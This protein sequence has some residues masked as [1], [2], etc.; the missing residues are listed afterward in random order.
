VTTPSAEELA[1]A[2]INFSL[3]EALAYLVA[4]GIYDF[5]KKGY[6]K[7]KKI[8]QD[9]Q[10]E[11]KYAFV[12][13]KEE[14]NLLLNS[15]KNPDYREIVMLIPN[16]RYI[17]LIRTGQLIDYYLKQDTPRISERVRD[18]KLQ[19]AN[20]PNGAKLLKIA[21]LP[22]TPYFSLIIKALHQLKRKGYSP[23]F[24]EEKFEE[25]VQDWTKT[26]KL[27]KSSDSIDGV[28]NFCEKQMQDKTEIFFILGMK[29]ASEKVERV[30]KILQ[31]KGILENNDYTYKLTKSELGVNPRVELM[32]FV[33]T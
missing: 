4:H 29:S 31:E 10:N 27:V 26:A 17:D 19:I 33:K 12:P 3:K 21:T 7:I 24:L 23:A 15:A 22:T 2:I 11:A 6:E 20:R 18:I 25:I 5:A 16:Y 30:L 9:K 32:F 1:N 8:I 28:V 13:D 14:A